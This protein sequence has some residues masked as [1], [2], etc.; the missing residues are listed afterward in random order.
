MQ[1]ACCLNAAKHQ[2]FFA[3][4]TFLCVHV[5]HCHMRA[6]GPI[7]SKAQ[8]LAFSPTAVG[9]KGTKDTGLAQADAVLAAHIQALEGVCM[10]F[11]LDCVL[12]LVAV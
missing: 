9:T 10:P 12:Y 11:E 8:S 5:Y 4:L 3:P 6:L 7:R 1:R 2:Q